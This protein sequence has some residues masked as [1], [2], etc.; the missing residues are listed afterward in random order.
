[1]KNDKNLKGLSKMLSKRTISC[2]THRPRSLSQHSHKKTKQKKSKRKETLEI[3]VIKADD[4]H[5]P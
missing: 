5:D 4:K 2:D 3:T 1:M